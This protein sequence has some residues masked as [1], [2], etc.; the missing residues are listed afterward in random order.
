MAH[1]Q[2]ILFISDD[3]WRLATVHRDVVQWVDVADHTIDL[4]SRIA[5]LRQCLEDDARQEPQVLLALPS[6]W[7]LSA[8]I[9][10]RDLERSAR[11]EALRFRLE[12]QLPISAEEMV[13]DF[14]Q[15]TREEVLGVCAELARIDPIVAA[16]EADGIRVR[17]IC[18]AVMLAGS[19]AIEQQSDAG[20]VLIGWRGGQEVQEFDFVEFSARSPSRWWWVSDDVD[21]LQRCCSKWLSNADQQNKKLVVIGGPPPIMNMTGETD[22]GEII[23]V[24]SVP[25]AAHAAALAGAEVLRDEAS[26]WI[27]LRSGALAGPDRWETFRRQIMAI[28][29]AVMFLL[30]ATVG[31]AVWRGQQYRSLTEQYVQEQAEVFRQVVPDQ[32]IPGNIRNR[33][34]SERQKLAGLGGQAADASAGEVHQPSALAH[35]QMVLESL[36]DD[37]RFR[38]MDLSIAP[39]LVRVDGR[40]RSHADADRIAAALRESG[41]YEVEPPKT[42]A[43]AE[44]GVSFVFTAVPRNLTTAG[45]SKP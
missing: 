18:P 34:L 16:L 10:S 36:P 41:L 27:D 5:A 39:D 24:T 15:I 13:A 1:D 37:L 32:R 45:A 20:A 11:H 9:S 44:R 23:P 38:V 6:S 19:W 25:D 28:A 26:A 40:A 31:V 33:L 30:A 35:L 3:T 42:Q 8:G 4:E 43:L 7:C 29:A 12:E 2:L 14:L 21:E 17:H 22:A